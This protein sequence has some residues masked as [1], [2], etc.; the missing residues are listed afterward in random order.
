MG[1]VSPVGSCEA[2]RS[3]STLRRVKT[4]LRSTMSEERL[5]GL[6]MMSVHYAEATELSTVEIVK[7]FIQSHPRRLFCNSILFDEDDA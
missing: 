4:H 7:R 2:E 6:T 5:A 1:C 3:F